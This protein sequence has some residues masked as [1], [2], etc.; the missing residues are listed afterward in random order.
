MWVGRDAHRYRQL[1]ERKEL[2]ITDTLQP[3]DAYEEAVLQAKEDGG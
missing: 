3:G 1:D 2:L